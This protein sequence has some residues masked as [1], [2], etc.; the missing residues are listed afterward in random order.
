MASFEA[1]AFEATIWAL[2]L[3]TEKKNEKKKELRDPFFLKQHDPDG[4]NKQFF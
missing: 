3:Q 1:E 4:L 2:E